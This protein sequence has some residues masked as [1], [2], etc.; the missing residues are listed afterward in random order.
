VALATVWQ[1]K[2]PLLTGPC[3]AHIPAVVCPA[4]QEVLPFTA[5]CTAC[6]AG[7]VNPTPGGTCSTTCTA[8]KVANQAGTECGGCWA[9]L[10]ALQPAWVLLGRGA[11]HTAG[12]ISSVAG[13]AIS[14]RG[15]SSA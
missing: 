1:V 4:G 15:R 12:S 14:V 3:A 11:C 13:A 6:P 8:P 10:P 7:T 2:N 5:T 9:W